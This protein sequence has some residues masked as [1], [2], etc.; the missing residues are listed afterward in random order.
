MVNGS[1]ITTNS[2]ALLKANSL[3]SNE[4]YALSQ[5]HNQIN[6]TLPVISQRQINNESH[7]YQLDS[8]FHKPP[9][10]FHEARQISEMAGARHEN[11]AATPSSIA[12]MGHMM[13]EPQLTPM[14]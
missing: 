13:Q 12:K 10:M 1:G 6:E 7:N 5:G 14:V 2:Q 8:S 11:G 4:K 3:K 9:S